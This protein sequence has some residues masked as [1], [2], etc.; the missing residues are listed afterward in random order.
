MQESDHFSPPP[1]YSLAQVIISICLDFCNSF[2]PGFP[3]S[4]SASLLSKVNLRDSVKRKSDHVIPLLKI[5]WFALSLSAKSKSSQC[6]PGPMWPGLCN[7]SDLFCSYL[8][9]AHCSSHT[10]L[11]CSFPLD[12]ASS[13][14]CTAHSD[15]LEAFVQMSSS[16]GILSTIAPRPLFYFSSYYSLPTLYI[17]FTWLTVSLYYN[18]SFMRTDICFCLFF[19]P[20]AVSLVSRRVVG[21]LIHLSWINE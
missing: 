15:L 13:T 9:P 7:L 4:T 14:I 19:F 2:L 17:L 11:C 20:T 10:D 21:Y 18:V 16:L 12:W 1:L 8:S 5:L 6:L 3:F